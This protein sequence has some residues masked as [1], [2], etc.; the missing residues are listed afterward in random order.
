MY[1]QVDK[2]LEQLKKKIREE[3]NRLELFSFD[4]INAPEVKTETLALYTRLRSF[5]K[6]HYLAIAKKAV[7]W[8]VERLPEDERE[9]YR[10]EFEKLDL[11]LLVVSV[12]ASYN[13]VTGYLYKSESERKR[14]RQAEEMLTAKAANSRLKYR[15]A[16]RRCAEL[17]YTQSAQYGIDVEDAAINRVFEIAGIPRVKWMAEDDAKTC[18]VCRERAGEIYPLDKLP[19]KP[20]YNCRCWIVPVT[21]KS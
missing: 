5:N 10:E 18:K 21:E 19:P 14:M 9:K 11:G 7:S 12:L 8:A 15:T 4:R 6:R 3:F 13:F 20:H 2:Y 1:E 17:W 16:L